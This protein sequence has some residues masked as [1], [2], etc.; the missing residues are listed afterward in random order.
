MMCVAPFH[1]AVYTNGDYGI[2]FMFSLRFSTQQLPYR[3]IQVV[4]RSTQLQC[5]LCDTFSFTPATNDAL[6]LHITTHIQR[7]TSNSSIHTVLFVVHTA[8]EILQNLIFYG[9]P[10]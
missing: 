8:S 7:H 3:C 10:A 6:V 4:K 9:C 2:M 1:L 5:F